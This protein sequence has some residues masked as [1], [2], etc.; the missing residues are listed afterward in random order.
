M[1]GR[2]VILGQVGARE[3]A[4]LY[5]DGVL[6]DLLVDSDAPRPGTIYRA[7]ATRPVKGQG[8]MFFDTPDGSAFLRGAK[9][10]APGEMHLVQVSG[11]AERGKAIPVTQKLLFKSR[12][13]IVTPDAPGVNISRAI[14][15]EVARGMIRAAAETERAERSGYGVILRSACAEAEAD[16]IAEDVDTMVALAKA[17][18]GDAGAGLETLTEGDGPHALAWREWQAD[19]ARD[20]D[21]GEALDAAQSVVYRVTKELNATRRISDDLYA[22]AFALLGRDG[23]VDL[24][25]VLG[26]YTLISMT[27]KAFEV[28]K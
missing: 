28:E 26:Y 9:G 17:V 20:G 14:K 12:Y 15:D 1:K 19:Q 27:I 3:A 7:K 13:A 10:L 2:E 18:L 8:G 21:L 24:I 22:E 16:A 25:G 6:D 4:A 23:L 5:V 11:Y